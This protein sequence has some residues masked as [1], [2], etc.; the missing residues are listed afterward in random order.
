M[1]LAEGWVPVAREGDRT[2]VAT[3]EPPTRELRELVRERLGPG[4][5]VNMRT[6]TPMDIERT[7]VLCFR[8][9]IVRRS[10]GELMARR[11]DLSA[12]AGWS[13]GAEALRARG[14]RGDR[15]RS[16]CWSSGS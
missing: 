1:L 15:P 9:H 11:P 6:T 10:T 4:A 14:G 16:D 2:I 8:E 12:A 7:I 5:K 13:V 3:C